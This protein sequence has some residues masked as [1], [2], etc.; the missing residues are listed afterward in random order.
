MTTTRLL[1]YPAAL[2]NIV[3]RL[4]IEAGDVLLDRFDESGH[5]DLETVAALGDDA[6]RTIA[7]A[8]R[9]TVPGVPVVGMPVLG[10]D[11]EAALAD[12]PVF[13][14]VDALDGREDFIGGGGDFTVNIALIRDGEPVLGVV[15]AP[16]AGELYAGSGPET[17]IRWLAGSNQEKQVSVR[18]W[19]KAGLTVMASKPPDD[20]V[21]LD[22]F[23]R[24]YKVARVTH[25]AS[26]LKICAIAAGRADLYPSFGATAQCQTA[27]GDAVLR[28]AGGALM[29][30]RNNE[31]LR[32]GPAASVPPNPA[33]I[34]SACWTAPI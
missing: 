21:K 16:F 7:E 4:A 20:P 24:D 29:D 25:R 28:S 3:R 33:F 2:C 5:A 22:L 14:L 23:L 30:M 34:A 11:G 19:P 31:K 13:W 10:A 9:R 6:A 15:Y 32:Y 26:S 27:A 1:D 12:C 17:A 8:L 18:P